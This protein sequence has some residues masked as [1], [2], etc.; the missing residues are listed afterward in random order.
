M[1]IEIELNIDDP[2]ADL[3]SLRDYLQENVEGLQL[4]IRTQAP[5]EG[6]MSGWEE[7][8]GKGMM[9]GL[10][11][12]LGKVGVKMSIEGGK[13]IY[14]LIK[15]WQKKQNE[16]RK[17]A[18]GSAETIIPPGIT[19][20]D[21][22]TKVYITEDKDGKLQVFDNFD[23]AIDTS[24]TYALLVGNSEFDGNF[25]SIPP[26]RNNLIDFYNLLVDKRHVGL[27]R[28]NVEVVLNKTSNEIEELMLKTSRIPNMETLI[29]YYTGH[30]HKADRESL[31]L[32]AK[33]T[34]RVDDDIIGGVDFNF[35]TDKVLKRSTAKQK[36]LIIDACHSGLAAQGDFDP[37]R[38][39]DVKG[40]YILTSSGDEA[41]YFEK[42]A[43]HTFFTGTLIDL[44][45]T[46]IND[47][48]KE[49]MSLED[50]YNFSSRKLVADKFPEPH[51]KNQLNI[52]A[53]VFMIAR[54]P[55]FSE[56]KLKQM[57]FT[58]VTQG[59]IKDALEKYKDLVRRFP[60]DNDLRR[61][62]D[63]CED[64]LRFE[65]LVHEADELYFNR[66]DYT[67]A[68]D[69]YKQALKYRKDDQLVI[70]RIAKCK[71]IINNTGEPI[72]TPVSSP[73]TPSPPPVSSISPTPVT[74]PAISTKPATPISNVPSTSPSP[75]KPPVVAPIESK[76]SY[77]FNDE[78]AIVS[79]KG[80][81]TK[82]LEIP[83]AKMREFSYL[84]STHTILIK[85][86]DAAGAS[87]EHRFVYTTK[88]K[89]VQLRDYLWHKTGIKKRSGKHTTPKEL[90]LGI[91]VWAVICLIYIGITNWASGDHSKEKGLGKIIIDI[92]AYVGS[93]ITPTV[94]IVLF[95]ITCLIAIVLYIIDT[96]A[97]D[98]V[99]T[100]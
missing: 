80:D 30:G 74:T 79:F 93:L 63:E 64:M 2:S 34:K 4:Q 9:Q 92:L 47:E 23:F 21:G 84:K 77:S 53:S 41:S 37:I 19:M 69:K 70:N 16:K 61:K 18:Q 1:Q 24:R 3:R 78:A 81:E 91:L 67:G 62:K 75:V 57:P 32:T 88:E 40:T 98:E 89:V 56:A 22:N 54:N 17:L 60:D 59:K 86:N 31:I 50:L 12:E 95:T 14:Q 85:F 76:E 10:W 27:P 71:E 39:F 94:V 58:L 8:I 11:S 87:R 6:T 82:T 66:K 7:A 15:E 44:L 13:K 90:G 65:E 29:L 35:V 52:T 36:I 5:R 55:N 26:V 51:F 96:K 97:A 100:R 83:Y 49:M 99:Y 43:R 48:T 46:G 45:R 28:E 72:S 20:G 25:P 42:K 73:S 38:D 68:I 33:N